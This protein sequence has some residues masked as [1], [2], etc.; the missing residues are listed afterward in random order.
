MELDRMASARDPKRGRRPNVTTIPFVDAHIHLWDLKRLSYPWL[1]PPFSADGMSGSVEA[2]A[3]DYGVEDYRADARR[4]TLAGAVHV[5]AGAS[6]DHALAETEWL[7]SLAETSGLPTGIVAFA[8]LNDPDVERVLE[9]HAAHPRV[10]GIRHIANWHADGFY[11]YTPADLLADPA[12]AKGFA[13]LARHGLSFDLQ[14]YPGQFEAAAVLAER[15]PDVPVMLNHCGM[16]LM[17]EPGG[18]EQWSKA[19]ARLAQVPQVS[20]K[21][22]GFGLMDHGWT[23]ESIRPYVLDTLEMFGTARCMFA[24]DFPTDKLYADFDTVIGA[25]DALTAD[26]GDDER[27]DLFGR[28]ANRLYRLGLEL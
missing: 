16:P 11:T 22:S 23:V 26:F 28:N 18:R 12:W 21:I 7:E 19:M 3:V 14:A 5:D 15:H 8:G 20:V 6:P 2:I 10:R 24:S 1:T 27:R 9:R 25:Y 4:W 17:G 13:A